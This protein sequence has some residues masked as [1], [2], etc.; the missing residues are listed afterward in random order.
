MGNMGIFGPTINDYGC[1]LKVI[2]HME[3][4]KYIDSGYRS[5]HS[6]LLLLEKG[7]TAFSIID[8]LWNA[9]YVYWL[10]IILY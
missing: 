9:N 1:L 2:K 8:Q 4:E 3:E 5:K 10:E 7:S 6:H